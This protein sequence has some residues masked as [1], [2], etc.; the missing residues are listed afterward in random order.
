MTSPQRSGFAWQRSAACGSAACVEVAP[1]DLGV[2]VRDSKSQSGPIL[3]YTR[4]EWSAFVT[5]VKK[6]EFD[7]LSRD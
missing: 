1:T 4:S 2:A 7:H 3:E 6:G 5:G